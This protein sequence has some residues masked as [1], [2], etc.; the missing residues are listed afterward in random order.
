MVMR[1][2]GTLILCYHR[3]AE[4]V[5]DPFGITVRPGNFAAQLDELRR[6]F[7][8]S[9]LDDAFAPSSKRR[10]VV[11]FDDG[12]ADNLWNALPIAEERGVPVT[13]FVTSDMVDSP[14]GMWWDRL[15]SIMQRRPAHPSEVEVSCN[16]GRL[17]VKVGPPGDDRSLSELHARLRRLPS[18]QIVG[19][20]E[21]LADAWS[22]PSEGP[23]DA[24]ML[25]TGELLELHRSEACVIGAHTSDHLCLAGHGAD[26]Q[27]RVVSRSK[28]A[29]ERMLGA[30][31]AHFA[32]PFGGADDFDDASVEAV[33][34]AGF[35]SACTTIA[36]SAVASSDP[37]RLPRRIVA[38]WGRARFRAQ[39]LRWELW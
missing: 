4:D 28:A 21:Q 2:P 16:G 17:S 19:V 5:L 12:Y 13:V 6:H 34:K 30:P 27:D 7:E 32:Y 36:G 38:D 24:R 26:E 25:T 9:T 1:R 33:R 15:A 29:L 10:V 22:I 18:V 20:L 14:A 23:P 31:V 39:L 11:T 3:V 8:P 37:L 35:A